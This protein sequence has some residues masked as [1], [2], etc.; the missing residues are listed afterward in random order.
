MLLDRYSCPSARDLVNP[1]IPQTWTLHGGPK[2]RRF[3]AP[4]TLHGADTYR[5]SHAHLT[6]SHANTGPDPRAP[7]KPA[8]HNLGIFFSL[9]QKNKL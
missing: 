6:H 3:L 8:A 4:R 2:M 1:V 7:V 5:R 9:I